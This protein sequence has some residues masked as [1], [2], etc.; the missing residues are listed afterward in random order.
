MIVL[1]K[2]KIM[3]TINLMDLKRIKLNIPGYL[4]K[5]ET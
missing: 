1:I 4:L 2:R 3:D 5:N